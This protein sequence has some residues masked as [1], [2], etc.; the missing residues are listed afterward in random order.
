MYFCTFSDNIYIDA[1][2]QNNNTDDT[3]TSV[4]DL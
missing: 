3:N 2:D 4:V 1:M